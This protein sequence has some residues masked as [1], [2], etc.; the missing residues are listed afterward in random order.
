MTRKTPA[1]VG[2]AIGFAL[3]LP[4]ALLPSLLYGGYAGVLLAGVL[5]GSPVA[6]GLLG[7]A[8]IVGGMVVGV[9]GVAILF[10]LG[11]AAAATAVAVLVRAATPGHVE[12]RPQVR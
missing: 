12:E 4:V 8:C 7:R 5:G 1:I 9:T 6:A 2:A 10:A 11:G 3:F